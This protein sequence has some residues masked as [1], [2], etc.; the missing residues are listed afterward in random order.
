MQDSEAIEIRRFL[1][2]DAQAFYRLRLEALENE[3]NAFTESPDEH[4]QMTARALA[5]LGTDSADKSQ[6]VLGACA[7]DE[8]IG[9]AGL[10]QFEPH[11]SRHKARLWGVYVRPEWRRKGVARV[12]VSELITRARSTPGIEQITLSVGTTQTAAIQLYRSLGFEVYGRAVRALK[13]GD[14][15]VDEELMV[16]HL[17]R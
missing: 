13:V 14:H 8:F 4:R 12:L 17:S 7:E 10:G 15:Y 11:K 9:M 6:V 2:P 16:L 3:P 1:E 5:K